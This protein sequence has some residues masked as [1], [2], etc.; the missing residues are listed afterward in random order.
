MTVDEQIA[1]LSLR[2]QTLTAMLP[3]PAAR[4]PVHHA[5]ALACTLGRG[6]VGM[7]GQLTTLAMTIEP[8]RAE[9]LTEVEGVL[10][11]MRRLIAGCEGA[12]VAL[13]E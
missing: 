2:W 12:V 7:L 11:E 5:L 6:Y 10:S 9:L 4:G 13:G 3:D 8:E 1:M